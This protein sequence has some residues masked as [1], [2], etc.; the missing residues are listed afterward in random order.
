MKKTNSFFI[1]I[2][3]MLML[4]SCIYIDAVRCA[5]KTIIYV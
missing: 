5:V 3:V 1:M 4:H 2:V